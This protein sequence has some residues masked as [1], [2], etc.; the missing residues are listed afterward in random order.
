MS[1]FSKLAKLCIESKEFVKVH[2]VFYLVKV[3][4]TSQS[5]PHATL[6]KRN[7]KNITFLKGLKQKKILTYLIADFTPDIVKVHINSCWAFNFY[8]FTN[9]LCCFVVD[10]LIK[11][12]FLY[13]EAAL[14][15]WPTYADNCATSLQPSN[16]DNEKYCHS[17]LPEKVFLVW[18]PHFQKFQFTI[19]L[20]FKNCGLEPPPPLWISVNLS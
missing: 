16:L 7:Y 5:L 11:T 18:T 14:F 9:I 10:C 6:D 4:N 19:I 3:Q 8:L 12:Y 17:D 13:E 15:I 2:S 1:V 20:S